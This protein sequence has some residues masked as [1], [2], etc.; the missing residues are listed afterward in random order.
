MLFRTSWK[1]EGASMDVPV[2][3]F[4]ASSF[5]ITVSV[6][7]GKPVPIEG[8]S[9]AQKWQPQTQAPGTGPTYSP[10]YPA[11]NVIGNV[12][13]NNALAFVNDRPVGGDQFSF[14]LPRDYQVRSVQIYFFGTLQMASWK[15]LTD[16]MST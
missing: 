14:S 12:G 3:I 15:V 10:N 4:N 6:N 13:H 16:G 1:V 5:P 2:S 11:I 8:T 7:N 9:A